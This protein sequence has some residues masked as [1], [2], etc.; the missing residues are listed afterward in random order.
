MA[1]LR[2]EQLFKMSVALDQDTAQMLGN[3][4]R[5]TRRIGYF[6]G[7]AFEGPNLRGE[8]LPGGG[9]WLLIRA[10]GIRAPDVRLTLRTDDDQLIYMSYQGIYNIPP[11][12]LQRILGGETMDSSEY[13]LRTTPVFETASEKYSWLNRLVAVGV[14]TRTPTG[15]DYIVYAIL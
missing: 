7:G 11:E 1:G 10:D 9:D 5:G 8:V 6:K 14:G 12:L 13:Y 4:P 2:S 15:L 3:T